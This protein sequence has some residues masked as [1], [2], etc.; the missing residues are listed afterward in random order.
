MNITENI[1]TA[2]KDQNKNEFILNEIISI[3]N[4]VTEHYILP[5]IVSEG[6]LLNATN[7]EVVIGEKKTKL[8]KKEFQLLYYLISNKNRVM[9]RK[10][11]L[12]DVWGADIWVDERTIDVHI[13]KIRRVVGKSNLRTIKCIGYG[14]FEK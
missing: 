5:D 10:N 9:Y 1:I 3:I 2:L 7:F 12:R 8:P 6:V 4:G 11:I 13:R 14:W